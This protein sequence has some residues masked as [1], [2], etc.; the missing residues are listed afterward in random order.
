M[1]NQY[2]ICIGVEKY[3]DPKI[4]PVKYAENDANGV[5]AAFRGFGV[6]PGNC[7][8]LINGSATKTKIES[9]VRMTCGHLA[10][11]DE[12]FF[13]YAGHG[14]ADGKRNY[15]TC[16]DTVT[17]D[18][19]NTVVGLS[20]ILDEIKKSKCR[21]VWLFID[22]CHSGWEIDEGLRSLFDDMTDAEFKSFC[23]ESEHHLAFS[24]C[25]LD[26]SSYS[27]A[28]L[29]HGIWTYHLLEALDGRAPKA[30]ERDRF[31]TGTSLQNYLR[32][33]VPESVRKYIEKNVV[34]TPMVW[35]TSSSESIIADLAP[36]LSQR[37]LVEKVR[38]LP[39]SLSFSKTV[40][41][42]I[43]KL[44]GFRKGHRIPEK[45]NDTTSRFVK[46]IGHDLVETAAGDWCKTLQ[47]E[48]GFTRRQLNY[49][50]VVDGSAVIRVPGFTLSICLDLDLERTSDYTLRTEIGEFADFKIIDSAVF[51]N[52][53]D[54]VFGK[55]SV[56]FNAEI[57]LNTVIDALEE[58]GYKPKYEWPARSCQ[59][60]LTNGGA[61]MIEKGSLSIE[62]QDRTSIRALID[63][64]KAC[65][66]LT[67][68]AG[69]VKYL[70]AS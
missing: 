2:A 29:K 28:S 50:G 21:K 47:S 53:F 25:K 57:N 30:L 41:G 42:R 15:V 65:A 36:I 59:L 10:E 17:T 23:S 18:I 5:S 39:A 51:S 46:N 1:S 31:V 27:T 16:H 52:L 48:F 20:W 32:L 3:T 62:A 66:L 19:S 35:G 61:L 40:T 11:E 9:A 68:D 54:D 69:L 4:R 14:W 70:S 55:L 63:S 60:T 24:A 26:Q 22:A 44:N 8:A 58:K 37:S 13:F 67:N 6:P 45:Y 12:L 49:D 56:S 33:V 43:T 7:T 38:I 64:F 34:Q